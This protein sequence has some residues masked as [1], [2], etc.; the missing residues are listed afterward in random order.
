MKVY[1]KKGDGGTTQL[2]GGTRVDKNNLRIETYGTLDELNAFIGLLH[3]KKVFMNELK[4][5]MKNIFIIESII[6]TDPNVE[7]DLPNKIKEDDIKTL[8]DKI[9]FMTN[10]MPKLKNFILPCGD[11]RS[12]T[13]HVCRTIT[14]RC[15]RLMVSLGVNKEQEKI[16][17]KYI[18]R[19]SDY[20]FTLARY[21]LHINNKEEIKWS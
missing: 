15:E 8:E 14:R 4:D 1:T 3:D 20:F 12:S 17:L 21:M 10:E 13:A 19:L 9:D 7:V 16:S 6:A 5:I 18:N 11:E 2:I